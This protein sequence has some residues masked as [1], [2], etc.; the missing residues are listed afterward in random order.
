VKKSRFSEEKII[1]VLKQAEAGVKAD[2]KFKPPVQADPCSRNRPDGEREPTV[3]RPCPANPAA[4]APAR[5]PIPPFPALD[6]NPGTYPLKP[7]ASAASAVAHH[8]RVHSRLD[9]AGGARAPSGSSGRYCSG[10]VR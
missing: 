10:T 5:A 7:G 4:D 9:C 2:R 3:D 6:L 1:A 8:L